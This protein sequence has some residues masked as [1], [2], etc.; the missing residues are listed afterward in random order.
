MV[1]K[2]KDIVS[3]NK[4]DGI[5]SSFVI[6]ALIKWGFSLEK[7]INVAHLYRREQKDLR[8]ALTLMKEKP[9]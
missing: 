3:S 2:R 5:V 8:G 4:K 7:R 9:F 6:F 1:L